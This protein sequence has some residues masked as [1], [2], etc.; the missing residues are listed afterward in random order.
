MENFF[1]LLPNFSMNKYPVIRNIAEQNGV[2]DKFGHA[3][4]IDET[5][6]IKRIME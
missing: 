3:L 1:R 2:I 4:I 6:A 5:E